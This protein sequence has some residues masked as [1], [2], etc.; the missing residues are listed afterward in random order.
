MC[1]S[2][3]HGPRKMRKKV[4]PKVIMSY[5]TDGRNNTPRVSIIPLSSGLG[6]G[7]IRIVIRPSRVEKCTLDGESSFVPRSVRA[8]GGNYI[9]FGSKCVPK[10]SRVERTVSETVVVRLGLLPMTHGVMLRR[11]RVG[12]GKWRGRRGGWRRVYRVSEKY[13][14]MLSRFVGIP[15]I[16]WKYRDVLWSR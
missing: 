16:D 2:F 4:E 1:T 3:N 7:P 11:L 9:H 12:R 15:T 5:S 10:R 13:E 8:L 6:S 14:S